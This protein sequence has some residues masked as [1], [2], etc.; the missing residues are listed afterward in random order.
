MTDSTTTNG[1]LKKS[2]FTD[3]SDDEND[4]HLACKMDLARSHSLRLLDNDIKEYSQWFAGKF[5]DVSDALSR[6]FHLNNKQLTNLLTCCSLP[7]S[8]IFLH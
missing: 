5:N 3:D 8:P 4:S 7:A 2:N 6:D 1:W